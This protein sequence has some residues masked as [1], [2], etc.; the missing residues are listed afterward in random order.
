MKTLSGYVSRLVARGR[1]R[2]PATLAVVLYK[3]GTDSISKLVMLV[4]TIVAARTLAAPEF[5]VFALAMTTGWLLSVASDAG[6]PL[7][8]A[9]QIAVA[10][11]GGQRPPFALVRDAMR[12]RMTF[13]AVAVVAG[14]A[15]GAALVPADAVAP[16]SLIVLAQLLNASLETLGHAF[17]G[18]GR[19]AVEA[20]LNVAQRTGAG[21][22]AAL[23]L[24]GGAPLL[25]A[26]LALALPPAVALVTGIVIARQ[27]T[28]PDPV[29]AAVATDRHPL[30]ARFVR[31]VAPVGAAVLL[32]AL[33]FRCDV[34]F[35]ER[36]HGLD[37]VGL[38]NGAFRIVEALRLFPAAV[39]AVTFPAF[40]VARSWSP[41]RSVVGALL[42]V[43][44]VLMTALYLVAPDLLGGL[45]G[46]R[47][48][49]AAPALGVLALALPF[50]FVNYALTHQVIAWEGQ[51]MYLR[52]TAA[53]LATNVIANLL[54]IP[55]DGL[56]GA[57]IATLITEVAVFAGCIWALAACAAIRV[58]GAGA[59]ATPVTPAAPVTVMSGEPR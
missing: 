6:L 44:V 27:M 2:P 40:C 57:A 15:L 16:F 50:F 24:A 58:T 25:L 8:L 41:L 29:D 45:Y 20:S 31:D 3:A 4:V 42:P 30:S 59:P 14:I 1:G 7:D 12:W 55:G 38:Y 11:S 18:L 34:Y 33:Y 19:S 5:G 39:M 56:R 26:A 36:W 53:A 28:A 49:T 9:K 51:R 23:V 17:R 21:L 37:A 54:L 10:S 13:A 22:A 46:P 35:I 43:S 32:S 52:I 47:F 48:T